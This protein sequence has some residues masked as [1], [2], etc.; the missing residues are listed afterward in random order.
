MITHKKRN[1][2]PRIFCNFANED[3]ATH[4]FTDEFHF[5][6]K[7]HLADEFCLD[8][9]YYFN[10][11]NLINNSPAKFILH[12]KNF[13]YE[14]RKSE[15]AIYCPNDIQS[16]KGINMVYHRGMLDLRHDP[17]LM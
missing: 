6:N 1:D 8:N 11:R 16:E 10:K 13:S 9:E 17:E 2:K 12:D 7:F 5:D 3:I 15:K 4:A 14:T